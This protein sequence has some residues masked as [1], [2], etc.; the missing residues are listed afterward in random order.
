[1]ETTDTI[2]IPNPSK[3]LVAFIER[4]QDRKK[5]RTDRMREKFLHEQLAKN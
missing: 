4:A 2:R 1:M 5:E 3:E